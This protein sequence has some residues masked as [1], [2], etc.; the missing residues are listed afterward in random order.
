M[1]VTIEQTREL[2][3]LNFFSYV[4]LTKVVLPDMI[5]SGRGGSVVVISS[6]SGH[7]GT[8]VGSSYSGR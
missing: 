5:S 4:S 8:P 1:D 2:M 7:L 3:E 6:L